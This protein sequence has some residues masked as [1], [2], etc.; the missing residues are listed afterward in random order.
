[1]SGGV[2][3]RRGALVEGGA[4]PPVAV[5]PAALGVPRARLPVRGA[6]PHELAV[7][8][9]PG[10][11][12]AL[13]QHLGAAAQPPPLVRGAHFRG[14]VERLPP[15][16][17]GQVRFAEDARDALALVRPPQIRVLGAA[18]DVGR[19]ETSA[20]RD[21]VPPQGAASSGDA[22]VQHPD[23]IVVTPPSAA[24]GLAV[25]RGGAAPRPPLDV[26]SV[27]TKLARGA[28]G[29]A[30]RAPAREHR[31]ARSTRDERRMRD[32]RTRRRAGGVGRRR[33]RAFRSAFR[34]AAHQLQYP[35]GPSAAV[36]VVRR[37]PA[38]ERIPTRRAPRNDP[39]ST[40][41]RRRAD[42][43]AVVRIMAR[44]AFWRGVCLFAV[45]CGRC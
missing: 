43:P 41:G 39:P 6:A 5:A 35:R 18:S 15:V 25:R 28:G 12:R 16:T 8:P 37:L 10:P 44:R 42:S 38:S 7:G 40:R 4:G 36:V 9:A 3:G 20:R 32:W 19:T 24:P 27:R 13:V 14:L 23:G 11:P 34:L 21:L 17:N 1:M 33:A 26:S 45:A 30:R 31:G 29:V 22:A 2:R